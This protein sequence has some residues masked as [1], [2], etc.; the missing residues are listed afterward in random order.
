MG[1]CDTLNASR[2]NAYLAESLTFLIGMG[3]TLRKLE[4]YLAICEMN[5]VVGSRRKVVN[6]FVDAFYTQTNLGAV[7][8]TAERIS[9][10]GHK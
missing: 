9:A 6:M 10:K 4:L 5:N 2:D 1:T 8:R 7:A 3:W